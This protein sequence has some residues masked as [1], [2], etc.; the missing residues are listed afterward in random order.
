[1]ITQEA[2]ERVEGWFAGRLPAEW[3]S[4]PADITIDREE[5]TVRLTIP[6]V[7]LAADA[8]DVARSEARAG[9]AKAFREETR[10]KRMEIAR[11]AEHRYDAKVSW[12]VALGAGDD[13][14]RELWTHVAAPV[15]TRLRQ[16]QRLVLDTLVDAGVARSRAD[17]LAWCVRLV[18]QHEDDWLT[19]LRDAMTAVAD[20]RS[21][22][23]AA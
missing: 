3:Q 23:P 14:H 9:R 1:M 5:I 15:M 12:G 21:K 16:P 11:E 10:T 19:E 4:A 8:S 2:R 20:V 18:G 6:D 7:D 22:G 13:Q 17:A